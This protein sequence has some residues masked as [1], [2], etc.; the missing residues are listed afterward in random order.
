MIRFLLVA[1]VAVVLANPVYDK[2][3]TKVN[4]VC[5]A[6]QQPDKCRAGFEA[7]THH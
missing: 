6:Q 3:I 1:V 2:V 5:H 4:D 7:L